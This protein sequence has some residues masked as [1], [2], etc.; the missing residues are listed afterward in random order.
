MMRR[1]ISERALFFAVALLMLAGSCMATV[2]AQEWGLDTLER[3]AID[4]HGGGYPS[5][6]VDSAGHPRIAYYDQV[7][8]TL[9]YAAWNNGWTIETVNVAGSIQS[10][11][12]TL[13]LDSIDNPRICYNN[14]TSF[15]M[16]YA[17][18][19][20]GGWHET[21]VDPNGVIATQRSMA[22]NRTGFPVI[23]YVAIM[24]PLTV[25]VAAFDGTTWA[26]QDVTTGV[27]ELSL[28]MDP[29]TDRPGIA[30][31]RGET[32]EYWES[33]GSTWTFL[34]VDN[35]GQVGYSPSIAFDGAGN[36][37]IAHMDISTGGNFH[38]KYAWR[39]SSGWHNEVADGNGHC[40]WYPSLARDPVTGY[41]RISHY[42]A[43]NGELR[44]SA[45]NGSAWNSEVPYL[46]RGEWFWT[47]LAI[48][49]AGIP[50]LAYYDNIA[51]T[52]C[53]AQSPPL[54]SAAFSMGPRSGTAPLTVYFFGNPSQ[55][56]TSW[57][58]DFNND[59]II[60]S[61]EPY[62]VH[63]FS[64]G[65]TYTI[66]LT[67]S[68]PL[69]SDSRTQTITVQPTPTSSF[70][71]YPQSGT[72]PLAVR[73]F[74]YT[75][76]VK[77]R[78]WD[79][80]D[81]AT[82][83]E[84]Y[85]IHVYNR[86]GLYTVTLTDTNWTNHVLMK[87]EF[88]MVRVTDPVTPAPTPVADFSAN[89][90]AGAA[91]LTVAFTDQSSPT[92]SHRWWQFGDGSSSTDASPV[93]TYATGGTY[94]VNLS[95]WTAI[96]TATV[97][98]PA[99]VMVGPDARAPVANFTVSRSSGTAPLFVKFTDCSTGNPTSWRW[100]FGGLAWTTAKSPS[101]VFRRPGTY[102][103]S[104]TV[105][106]AYGSSISTKDVTVTGAVGTSGRDSPISVV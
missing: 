4:S 45:F 29:V 49:N 97:S 27:Y 37:G 106:N 10:S 70:A 83:T 8:D 16:R 51:R 7:T 32:L 76:N 89:A 21:M 87:T 95:V 94:T 12:I 11:S 64:I 28:D 66:R 39:N 58:W 90:T 74:D 20:T 22:L 54:P 50:C 79:F 86:S 72:A 26:T 30:I 56:I 75:P 104:L 52:L 82:S 55:S 2:S 57:A 43:T 103:V 71:A 99:Y 47:S 73:F 33:D 81:N 98:R 6:A 53:Y 100:N 93:H 92:P 78:L 84:Q 15:R 102:A 13:V 65:G 44:Y 42:D 63:T 62:P 24:D 69:G 17:W 41:P 77:T 96:G 68:G 48:N 105:K 19:D 40:G 59:G 80:G 85:P 14:A 91:P 5:I 25:R 18:K 23:A 88:H 61:T 38:V 67:V 9:K 101:V 1:T 60:E 31:K 34:T 46:N 36:P 3:V 35:A